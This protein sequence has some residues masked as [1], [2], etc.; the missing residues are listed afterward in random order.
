MSE[1]REILDRQRR[2]QHGRTAL[3]WAEKVRMA[4]RIRESARALRASAVKRQDDPRHESP[5]G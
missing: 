3:S 4:E 2:W 1:V 5:R